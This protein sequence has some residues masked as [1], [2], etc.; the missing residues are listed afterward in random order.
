MNK[1]QNQNGNKENQNAKSGKKGRGALIVLC[2]VFLIL[3]GV[4]AGVI[5]VKLF[6]SH[7]VSEVEEKTGAREDLTKYIKLGQYTDLEVSIGV[8][9]EELQVE[10]DS[11]LEEY[12]TYEKI[13][14]GSA[15]DGDMVYAEYTGYVDGTRQ[16]EV[17]GSDY[18]EIGLGDWSWLPGYEEAL[19]GMKPGEEK[20]ITVDMQEGVTGDDAVDGHQV[21]L[22]IVLKYICGDAI[23]PEYDDA[24]VASIS[25]Y[26]TTQEYDQMLTE[27][28][29]EE[30]EEE[31]AEY[32]WSEA[33]D[34][35]KVKSYPEDL[36]EDAEQEVLQGYYDMA[37]IY[38]ISADEAFQMVGCETEEE[39]RE[40]QL[41]EL[42]QDTV[43]EILF[44]N[45][46][47]YQEQIEYSDSDYQE[48]V[49]DEY[50]YNKDSYDSQEDYEQQNETYLKN[51]ALIHAVKEWI[52]EH[53]N[54]TK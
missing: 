32:S 20:Q 23:V 40:T 4:A 17:C 28:L 54:Y 30:Y 25:N 47:A 5:G 15:E 3:I 24:F 8:T 44:A 1:K 35:A 18:V 34:N 19:I 22:H 53:T 38:G 46:V 51:T 41:E 7:E 6:Q 43:K 29:E 26:D 16:D 49:K 9:Q 21:E 12:T 52:S 27:Q 50:E 48:I 31:K 33:L 36:M 14:T 2:A 10:I 39:F 37:E 42:A 13:K 11:L 45:A